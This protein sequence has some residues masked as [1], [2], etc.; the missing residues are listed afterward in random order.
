MSFT[1]RPALRLLGSS[2]LAWLVCS[3]CVGTPEDTAALSA[4]TPLVQAS[5]QGS[6]EATIRLTDGRLAVGSHDLSVEL[7]ALTDQN[8]GDA[9]PVLVSA[10]ASMPAHGHQVSAAAISKTS[11]GYR[12]EDLDL[13]MSGRWQVALGVELD[14]SSDSVDFALDVP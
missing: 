14:A 8:S 1:Q 4:E 13:F 12:V 7:T 5:E 10:S 3:A 9:G 2:L 6:V 11:S